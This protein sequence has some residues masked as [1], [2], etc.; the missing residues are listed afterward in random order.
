M[1]FKYH[2]GDLRLALWERLS[3]RLGLCLGLANGALYLILLSFVIYAFSYWT[4]QMATSDKDPRSDEDPESR[5]AEDLQSSGFVKVARA[6]D[7]MPQVWYD[8]ADLAGTDLQ[9]PPV[10][11]AAG[12][13]P[14]FARPGRAAGVPGHGQR[15]ASSPNYLLG[16]KPIK[17]VLDHPKAQAVLQNPGP[18]ETDLGHSGPRSQGPV[19]LSWRAASQPSTTRRRFSAVG[20]ST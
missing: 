17:T 1:H 18:A 13:I 12:A 2:A 8:S 14:G 5:W 3:R 16:R 7:P 9:Q 6:I 19:R 15:H 11:S 10:R 4:V 20:T